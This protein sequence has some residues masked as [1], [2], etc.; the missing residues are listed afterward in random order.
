[1]LPETFIQHVKSTQINGEVAFNMLPVRVYT[2]NLLPADE[3]H[4]FNT[5]R[6]TCSTLATYS[7]NFQH[8]DSVNT[9]QVY[10]A[11]SGCINTRTVLRLAAA[12]KYHNFAVSFV[13]HGMS[14]AANIPHKFQEGLYPV[15][16]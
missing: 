3:Q 2:D 16:S 14:F 13:V 8:I 5:L 7:T 4:P 6:E 11:K 10:V 12:S 15:I 9:V 1:M